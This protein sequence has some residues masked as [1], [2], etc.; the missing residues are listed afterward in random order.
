M[1]KR[2]KEIR[3]SLKL[4][5]ESFGSKL[6]VT[7]TAICNIEKGER[8]VTDQMF[9]SICREFNINE[10]WL[11]TGEGEMFNRET[12]FSLDEFLKKQ[13]ATELLFSLDKNTR[14]ELISKLKNIFQSETISNEFPNYQYSE[15]TYTETYN[16]LSV[17]EEP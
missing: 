17:A 9:K 11:R 3:K 12:S 2:F 13:E 14:G 5:Q 4:T 7:R 1:N 10:E 16:E 15:N 8:N 6:G